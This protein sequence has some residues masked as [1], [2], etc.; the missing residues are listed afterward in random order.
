MEEPLGIDGVLIVVLSLAIAVVLTGLL[1]EFPATGVRPDM[2]LI[3]GFS[4]PRLDSDS[5]LVPAEW[6]SGIHIAG[7][8]F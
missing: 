2:S 6:G 4:V 8:N 3:D 7:D 1:P 5:A